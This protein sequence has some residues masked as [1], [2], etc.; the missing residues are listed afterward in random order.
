MRKENFF[1]VLVIFRK[2]RLDRP[3]SQ[4]R[5]DEKISYAEQSH[6]TYLRRRHWHYSGRKIY[7]KHRFSAFWL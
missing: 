5:M 4:T 7:E 1:I 6:R 2:Q 3:F